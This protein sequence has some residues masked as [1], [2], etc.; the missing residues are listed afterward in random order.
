MCTSFSTYFTRYQIVQTEYA[1]ATLEFFA[2]ISCMLTPRLAYS[3]TW[4]RF[5]NHSGKVDANHPMDLD[6]EHDN[7]YFKNDIYI[8]TEGKSQIK[9]LPE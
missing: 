7:K 2:R 4:N 6:L 9:V 5:V 8:A 3:L 1:F